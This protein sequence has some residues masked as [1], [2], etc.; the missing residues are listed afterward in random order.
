[1][2]T[3]WNQHIRT[4]CYIPHQLDQQ[5]V[6]QTNKN[7]LWTRSSTFVSTRILQIYNFLFIGLLP[8]MLKN[9]TLGSHC[10]LWKIYKRST[11]FYTRIYGVA[12][13]GLLASNSSKEPTQIECHRSPKK[14]G[15]AR[16]LHISKNLQISPGFRTVSTVQVRVH[17][18]S[19]AYSPR[20]PEYTYFQYS[21][22]TDMYALFTYAFTARYCPWRVYN[23]FFS[24]I[25]SSFPSFTQVTSALLQDYFNITS[26]LK[27]YVYF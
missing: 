1:M 23:V 14:R 8:M 19:A 24:R 25:E 22:V 3:A 2:W 26:L 10:R 5:Y 4:C 6:Q 15:S 12:L 17:R 13:Q 9:L 18:V 7:S 21:H 27:K 20:T 16:R 11:P